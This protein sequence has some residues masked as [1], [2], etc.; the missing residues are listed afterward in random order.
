MIVRAISTRRGDTTQDT[1]LISFPSLVSR[2]FRRNLPL[3]TK[4][5]LLQGFS[6]DE[7]Q[8]A[9]LRYLTGKAPPGD[10]GIF[11]A[12]DFWGSWHLFAPFFQ[13]MA[14][15]TVG[16]VDAQRGVMGV[17]RS[18]GILVIYI[19]LYNIIYIYIFPYF[20]PLYF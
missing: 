1:S 16:C 5:M 12:H 14:F 11:G 9:H 3:T 8:D 4:R 6:E 18:S 19:Y 13:A 20:P 7:V 10:L 17:L 15:E 2:C